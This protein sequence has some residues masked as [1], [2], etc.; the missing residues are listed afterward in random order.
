L[1][2]LKKAW[3]PQTM[4]QAEVGGKGLEQNDLTSCD[5]KTSAS[6]MLGPDAQTGALALTDLSSAWT[7]DAELREIFDAWTLLLVAARQAV[8]QLVRSNRPSRGGPEPGPGQLEAS[9]SL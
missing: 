4:R 1:A 3:H 2:T 8:L 5:N 7:N 6:L 9:G